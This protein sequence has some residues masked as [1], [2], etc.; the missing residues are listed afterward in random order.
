MDD[1]YETLGVNKNATAAE[2]KQ[3]YR[4]LALKW[5]PDKNKSPEANQHFKKINEAFEVLSDPKKRQAYDQFGHA[6]TKGSYAQGQRQ[7]PRTYSYST[8]NVQDIF[9]AFGFGG[10]G[11][12]DPF[13]IFESFFG[14]RTPRSQPRRPAY[15]MKISFE[16]AA[17]GIEKQIVFRGHSK[18]IKIPAGVGTG[19]QIRFADF[20]VV[21]EVSPSDKYQR[22]GQDLYY[23]KTISYLEAIL[24]T[25]I[26]VPTFTK[27]IKLRIKPGT[28]P[29]T[30]VRLKDFGLLYPNSNRR[31]NLYVVI[32]VKIPKSVSRSERS[33]IRELKQ[34]QNKA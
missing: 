30:L 19:T 31:G 26:K 12:S 25:E 16:E 10:Q 34:L 9:E 4:K 8:G 28:Q 1:Y 20:T 14:F 32:K 29:N 24:G 11:F 33:L 21:V 27:E 23:E 18:K 2:I 22:D 13:D 7:G 6:G 3:S 17:Q 15:R 5:H